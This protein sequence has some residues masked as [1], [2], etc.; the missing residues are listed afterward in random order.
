MHR[1]ALRANSVKEITIHQDILLTEQQREIVELAFEYWL[2]RLG[3]LEGSP[4][5]DLY[6]AER[7]VMASS[8]KSR[9]STAGLFLVC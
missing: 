3:V 8:S 7:E 9:N 5:E 1:S 2:A 4:E 6:R